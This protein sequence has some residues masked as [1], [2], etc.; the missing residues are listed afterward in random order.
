M[1]IVVGDEN[2]KAKA[3][4]GSDVIDALN[5]VVRIVEIVGKEVTAAIDPGHKIPDFSRIALDERANVIAIFAVPLT[6]RL[7]GEAAAQFVTD[8]VPRFSDEPD[9]LGHY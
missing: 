2:V 3:I 8:R 1:F 7:A 9:V 5:R 4:V 6:P